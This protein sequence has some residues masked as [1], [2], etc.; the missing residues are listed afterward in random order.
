M[1][2]NLIFHGS[3]VPALA[4]K[5][6]TPL[7]VMS[8]DDIRQRC[9]EIRVSFTD[10]YENTVAAF[11]C[12]AFQTLEMIRLIKEEG[13]SLD[14][15]S[16]GELYA[17]LKAGFDPAHIGFHGNAKTPRELR[18]ALDAGVGTIIVD[19]FS[20]LELLNRLALERGICQ[21]ILL[22]VTPGVD[23]HTHLYIATGNLDSKFGFSVPEIK[24]TVFEQV[25][26][27]KGVDLKG[28]HYHVGSQ[29]TENNSHIMATGIMLDLLANLKVRF[30][31]VPRE[32]NCGGGFGIR[33]ADY[34]ERSAVSTFM[35]PVMDMINSFYRESGDPRPTVIIE[36]GRWIVG[37]AGITVYE[38]SSVKT[39]AAGR[40]YAGVN[41]GLSDNPRTALYDAKYEV[42]AAD[43][44]DQPWDTLTTIAGKC[45]ES[46]DIIA[47]DVM[48]PKMEIGDLLAVYS[49][50]AYN[51]SMAG[52]YNR[53]PRPAVVM[54]ENGEDHL[55]VRRETYEDMIEREL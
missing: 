6:G 17:A 32:L 31:Y 53:L 5:Y 41:G 20:E 26:E 54:I 16:G 10:K 38:V 42:A 24:K 23:S 33:Y 35:D 9:A 44:M 55:S 18:E 2:K 48:L 49:T 27:M 7:Y 46:G 50:G 36:P 19:N 34:P 25:R 28:F 45:C 12:K 3:D 11:A 29:L 8:I 52:N 39:N 37:E 43:K 22:R 14:I 13:L 51:Y 30:G 4:E 1:E 40:H 15:V 21:G 47:Y